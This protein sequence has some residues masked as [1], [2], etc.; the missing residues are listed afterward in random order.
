MLSQVT[1][2]ALCIPPV[3][4][5]VELKLLSKAD[6]MLQVEEPVA[7]TI[8]IQSVKPSLMEP[9]AHEVIPLSA[10]LWWILHLQLEQV[11]A[12]DVASITGKG[13][14]RDPHIKGSKKFFMLPVTLQATKASPSITTA[15]SLPQQLSQ[16]TN[17]K[18]PVNS[19][20]FAYIQHVFYTHHHI[21]ARL[22]CKWNL[23]FSQACHHCK[24]A[25]AQHTLIIWCKCF[26]VASAVRSNHS[27]RLLNWKR[28]TSCSFLCWAKWKDF[29]GF[30]QHASRGAH[31]LWVELATY[32]RNRSLKSWGARQTTTTVHQRQSS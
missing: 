1:T 5:T 9:T 7:L 31:I 16:Q 17:W 23:F 20:S 30:A 26:R 12:Q 2:I 32:S 21:K 11:T 22:K 18:A 8:V 24:C 3:N 13:N 27:Y 15:S 4:H 25:V 6:N 19:S 28:T 14:R 10:W 29:T